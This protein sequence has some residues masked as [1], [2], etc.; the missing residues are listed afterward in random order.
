[1]GLITFPK[2]TYCPNNLAK[3]SKLL[4]QEM[5]FFDGWDGLINLKN[6]VEL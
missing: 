2:K 3:D 1:M 6:A 5:V 4:S